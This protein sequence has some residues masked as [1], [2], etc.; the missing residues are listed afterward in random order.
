MRLTFFSSAT[1]GLHRPFSDLKFNPVEAVSSCAREPPLDTPIPDLVNVH[2]VRVLRAAET[3][4]RLLALPVRK[5]HHTPFTT[6]MVSEGTLAL[7]S[8]CNF[9]LKGKELTIAREQIRMTIG[10]LKTLAEL[11]PRTA[12]NVREIQTIAHHVLGLGS[13]STSKINAVNEYNVPDLSGGEGQGSLTSE[14]GVSSDEINL[15]PD[16]G[17][18]DDLCGWYNL[19]D[20]DPILSWGH[21]S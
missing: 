5:F 7:L 8:A 17:S 9:Q 14:T 1:I 11:W 4:I 19:G 3:Q 16:L 18:I 12:R 20:I 10:C 21:G 13:K 6:C 2:T 15:L